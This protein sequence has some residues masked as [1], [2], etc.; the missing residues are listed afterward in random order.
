MVGGWAASWDG[1][2]GGQGS[3]RQEK[4]G[5]VV[6]KVAVLGS[7]DVMDVGTT[8]SCR[9]VRLERKRCRCAQRQRVAAVGRYSHLALESTVLNGIVGLTVSLLLAA[10]SEHKGD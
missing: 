9:C 5:W 10:A 8:K 6:W 3:R 7:G 1:R 2:K 4:G